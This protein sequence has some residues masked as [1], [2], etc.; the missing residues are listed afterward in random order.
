MWGVNS[1]RIYPRSCNWA[2]TLRNPCCGGWQI[3]WGWLLLNNL[4]GFIHTPADWT[5]FY[6]VFILCGLEDKRGERLWGNERTYISFT[7]QRIGLYSI[8]YIFY[9]GWSERGAGCESEGM[10]GHVFNSH[11][12]GLDCIQ[13]CTYSLEDGARGGSR[14][15]SEG[16]RGHVFHSHS[17]GLDCILYCIYSLWIRG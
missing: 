2:C 14:C 4:L 10:R 15:E 17:S 12:S 9:G 3:S 8:L 5:V 6:T 13:Y 11:S 7:R 16:M 1:R